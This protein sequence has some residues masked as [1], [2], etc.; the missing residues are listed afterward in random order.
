MLVVS[1]F[2]LRDDQKMAVAAFSRR[3]AL[4]D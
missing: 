1:I 4:R 2:A 3:K